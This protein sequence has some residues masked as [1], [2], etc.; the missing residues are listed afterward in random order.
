MTTSDELK[1]EL[2]KIQY[3]ENYTQHRHL[4]LLFWS[5][6]FTTIGVVGI[7]SLQVLNSDL[8]LIWKGIIFILLGLVGFVFASQLAKFYRS[9][10]QHA[11]FVN[12]LEEKYRLESTPFRTQKKKSKWIQ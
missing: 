1:T 4:D 7:T 9:M 11:Q 5:T 10:D 3:Q 12:D 2:L 8:T 6:P